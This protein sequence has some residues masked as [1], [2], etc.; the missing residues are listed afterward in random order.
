MSMYYEDPDKNTIEL[1]YDSGYTE[2]DMVAFYA[3]GD[4]YILSPT[5]FDP[6]ELQKQLHSGK[7]VA[8]LIAWS[9]PSE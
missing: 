4:R 1:Y 8:E 2:E 5:P 6:A 3:G 7:S 9:P